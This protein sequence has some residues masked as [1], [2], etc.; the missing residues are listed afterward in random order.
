MDIPKVEHV[1]NFDLPTSPDEFDA[2]VHRIGRT[3]RAGN[4]GVSTSMYVPGWDAKVGNAGIA[5]EL[6]KLFNE[7]KNEVPDWHLEYIPPRLVFF[8]CGIRWFI[9][10][11]LIQI[12]QA[13]N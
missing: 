12:Y 2:Y 8:F 5:G 11:N 3:G 4:T 13:T 1:I 7:T 10:D 6:L 9:N